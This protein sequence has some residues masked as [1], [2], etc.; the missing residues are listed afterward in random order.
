[1]PF[2]ETSETH[3]AGPTVKE[4]RRHLG[5]GREDENVRVHGVT[6]PKRLEEAHRAL[7]L[8]QLGAGDA[9]AQGQHARAVADDFVARG[10]V[11]AGE[12]LLDV[13]VDVGGQLNGQLG[14]GDGAQVDLGQGAQQAVD[15]ACAVRGGLD[16]DVDADLVPC[17]GRQLAVVDT[18]THTCIRGRTMQ[19]TRVELR[20]PREARL[21]VLGQ[22]NEGGA[23]AADLVAQPVEK[24][25]LLVLGGVNDNGLGVHE[26]VDELWAGKRLARQPDSLGPSCGYSL[27]VL[28]VAN[29]MRVSVEVVT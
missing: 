5:M 24:V 6:R 11:E 10:P 25:R 7:L 22:L 4:L 17:W 3:G 12:Q 1:M 29:F 21:G 16:D 20:D 15:V 26:V 8:G 2:L 19:G 9:P 18:H 28:A 14:R 27:M 23:H 13:G